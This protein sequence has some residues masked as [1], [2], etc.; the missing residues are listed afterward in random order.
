[1]KHLE[2]CSYTIP[3]KPPK[4]KWGIVVKAWA[5]KSY[6]GQKFVQVDNKKINGGTR[7]RRGGCN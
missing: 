4:D 6:P 5:K 1:M 2:R 7:S 3:K